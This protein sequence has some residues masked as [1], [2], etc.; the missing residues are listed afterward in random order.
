MTA[1][2]LIELLQAARSAEDLR[3]LARRYR[4]LHEIPLTA[5]VG[6]RAL[7]VQAQLAARGYHRGP[8]VA[9]LLAAAAAEAV[10]AEVWHC[11]RHY[12]LIAEVTGQPVRKVG[13]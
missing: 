9:D 2:I 5:G 7:F 4:G 8:S 12:E 6:R 3:T 11:D 10:G 1:P 13:R